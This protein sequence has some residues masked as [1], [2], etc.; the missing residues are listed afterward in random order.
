MP[1]SKQA[2]NLHYNYQIIIDDNIPEYCRT[3]T[4]LAMCLGV[5]RSTIRNYFCNTYENPLRKFKG[6]KF[7]INKVKIPIY[8]SVPI[9]Y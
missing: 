2:S 8:E 4:D 9:I 5:S 6:T 7:I 3:Q 1:R